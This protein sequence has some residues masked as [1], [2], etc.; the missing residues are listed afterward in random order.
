MK[1]SISVV[2]EPPYWMKNLEESSSNR[3]MDLTE[4]FECISKWVEST[5]GKFVDEPIPT[6]NDKK[7]S[8][9]AYSVHDLEVKGMDEFFKRLTSKGKLKLIFYR[10]CIYS[11]DTTNPKKSKD[12]I[13]V[14]CSVI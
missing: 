3:V 6:I 12:R 14:R 5:D 11:G 9:S 10:Y 8:V 13:I 2:S 7:I 1:E 4:H